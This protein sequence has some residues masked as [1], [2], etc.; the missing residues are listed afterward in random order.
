MGAE[1][2]VG[3][4]DLRY[5]VVIEPDDGAF[6]VI[7]PAFPEI[8]TFGETHEEA[9]ELARD[10][11]RLSLEYRR[12][13]GLDNPASDVDQ[14]RV[15]RCHNIP[16]R[17]GSRDGWPSAGPTGQ[18]DPCSPARRFSRRADI[19]LTCNSRK[20]RRSLCECSA[21]CR[22]RCAARSAREHLENCRL[23]ADELRDLL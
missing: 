1:S 16:S 15:E 22:S 13:K 17:V 10:A 14:T 4:A 18:V 6:S 23:T 5:T 21:A 19:W 3:M 9:L 7:V 8:S 12:D 20:R 2:T 11:I